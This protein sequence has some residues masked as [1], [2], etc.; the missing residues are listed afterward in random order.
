VGWAYGVNNNG[1]EVGYSVEATCDFDGC[2]VEI[3]RGLAYVC[4][5][6]HDGGDLGCGEYFCYPHLVYIETG[7]EP[8]GDASGLVQVCPPCSDRIE[9]ERA[10][11]GE[12]ES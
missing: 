8:D 4:G 6:M 1:R 2:D 11:P 3:D 10:A 12:G 5:G 7:F 9:A